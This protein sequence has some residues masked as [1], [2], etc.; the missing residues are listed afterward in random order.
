MFFFRTDGNSTISYGHIMRCIAIARAL[1]ELGEQTCFLVADDNPK[2]VLEEAGITY[3]VL[4]SDWMDLMTDLEKVKSIVVKESSSVVLVDTYHIT[5]QY[6]DGLS[7]VCKVAYMGSKKAYL[8]PL[9]LLVNYSTD[10]DFEFYKT[11]YDSKT[12]LLLGPAYAPLRKEFQNISCKYV[13]KLE[14]ILIT[15]GNTDPSGI[16]FSLID[17]LLPISSRINIVLDVVVGRLYENKSE[18]NKEYG[19]NPYIV[20]HENAQ[21]M[22][23][24][25]KRCNL[26]VSAN[27]TTVYELSAMGVPVISFAMVEEQV[28]SAEAM[29]KLGLVDYCGSSYDDILGCTD[30]IVK[31]VSYYI[32]NLNALTELA[33]RAHEVIDGKGALKIVDALLE[34]DKMNY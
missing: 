34:L 5:E 28:R 27:G 15:T 17:G 29:D 14:R 8:G 23:G 31:R 6:V 1:T 19:D 12:H 3:I 22:S 11:F 21:S 32:N 33:K 9:A 2:D 7:S 4:H 24:L 16:V 30:R 25:M 13:E 18:L 20:L 10:I 26:A